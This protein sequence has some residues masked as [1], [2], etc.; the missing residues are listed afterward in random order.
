MLTWKQLESG[1]CWVLGFIHVML[2]MAVWIGGIDRFPPPN[3]TPLL[4]FTDGRIWPYAFLWASGGI[5]MALFQ[6]WWRLL[7]IGLVLIVTN[8]WAALFLVAAL[9]NPSASFT[10]TAA[11]GGYGLL[12]GIL[13]WLVWLHLGREN[14]G[15]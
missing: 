6:G 10:P 13:L 5:V 2:G 3:Y 4:D 14:G 11:Y 9:H 8:L 1:A 12:N 7:G 15:V